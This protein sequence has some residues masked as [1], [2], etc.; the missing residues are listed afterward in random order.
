M[1]VLRIRKEEEE[2]RRQ[3]NEEKEKLM[4]GVRYQTPPEQLTQLKHDE[5]APTFP[6]NNL[7]PSN[8]VPSMIQETKASAKYVV[9]V[10]FSSCSTIS[11]VHFLLIQLQ[12]SAW[13]RPK[14]QTAND[15]FRTFRIKN[16]SASRCSFS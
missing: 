10:D 14:P 16:R 11:S 2:K 1:E 3:Y 7:Y 12:R 4:G 13:V 6:A 8:Q 15:I 9:S 5:K